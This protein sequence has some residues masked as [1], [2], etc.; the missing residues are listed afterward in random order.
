M[1]IVVVPPL[2]VVMRVRPA[3]IWKALGMVPGTEITDRDALL[4]VLLVIDVGR[5]DACST[6]HLECKLR[7]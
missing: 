6:E 1:G 5:K 2:R 3:V 4:S 7:Q